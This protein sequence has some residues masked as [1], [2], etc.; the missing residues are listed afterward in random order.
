MMAQNKDPRRNSS[1]FSIFDQKQISELKEAFSIFDRDADGLISSD[2]LKDTLNSLGMDSSPDTISRM[3]ADA[4][5]QINFTMFL[6]MMGERLIGTD[7]QPDILAAFNAFD[8][9]G[10]GLISAAEFKD[11]LMYMGD[12]MSKDEV[13]LIFRDVPVDHNGL[14]PFASLAQK[15]KNGQ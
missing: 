13:D 6:T 5:G 15:L 10:S 1:A 12:R 9:S 11:A 2:D 7:S 3:L 4:P 14:V 8:D